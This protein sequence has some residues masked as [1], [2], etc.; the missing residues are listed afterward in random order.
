VDAQLDLNSLANSK[1]KDLV[2]LT[3][4]FVYIA[5]NYLPEKISL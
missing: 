5:V 3:G 2:S 4:G 1:I